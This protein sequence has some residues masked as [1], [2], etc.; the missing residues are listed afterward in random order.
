MQPM[1]T[2][3]ALFLFVALAVSA[4]DNWS[5]YRGPKGDGHAATKN[6]PVKWS[7][8][9]N[10]KWKVAVAGRAWSSPVIW[11]SQVWM[12]TASPDGKELSVVVVHKDTGKTLF[13]KKLFDVA[14]PQFAHKFNSYAS[15]TP[16]IEAG[17]AYVTWGSPATACIDT[18]SFKI[19]WE[20]RDLI[21]D[22]FRG[23]GS[24]PIFFRNLLIMN[25]DGADKQ[26]VTALDKTTG[27]SVW[28]TP[29]SVDYQDLDAD[30]KPLRDG[31]MRK[32]YA[33]PH[34]IW[35]NKKPMV[36]SSGAMAHYAYNPQNG[37]EIWR[38]EHRG[39]HSASA[40][41]VYGH[42][43]AYI[44]TGFS[45][46]EIL[47]VKA[48]SKGVLQD[49]DAAWISKRSV[50]KKPSLILTGNLLFAIDDG[51]IA[52]CYDAKT[53]EIHYQE[54]L[55][56]KA[57]NFSASPILANGR[58]YTSNENGSTFVL[59]AK[60]EFKV[61]AENHLEDG[62]MASPAVTDDALFLRTKTHLYRIQK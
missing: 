1:K 7:E 25:Y 36:L 43:N 46:G 20:R 55:A 15:P 8:T 37:K 35:I 40:R 31:D 12:T 26:Y 53:G 50:P 3:S 24:S 52:S 47:A 61:L 18:K 38:L 28:T 30:G 60:K 49:E 5:Q 19:L 34:I 14:E 39:Q 2:L 41:T 10:V 33:T 32:S 11:G 29:R 54:R 16:I 21:C 56:P 48:D 45:K 58:I 4:Q 62:C 51:G 22:H 59:A 23:A 42:G 27:K 13:E 57:G 6:L 44:T 17:R 9:E